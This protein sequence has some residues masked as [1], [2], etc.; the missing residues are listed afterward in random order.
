[1]AADIFNK[2]RQDLPCAVAQLFNAITETGEHQEADLMSY[3]FFDHRFTGPMEE[4]GYQDAAREEERLVRLFTR[5]DP[6][7]AAAN[8]LP[9]S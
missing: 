1:M 6:R 7:D 2:T 9:S 8:V 3:L 5:P 4:L